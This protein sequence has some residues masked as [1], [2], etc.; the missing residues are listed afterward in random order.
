MWWAT[1]V[2]HINV[3]CSIIIIIIIRGQIDVIL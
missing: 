1:L 3:M 2:C